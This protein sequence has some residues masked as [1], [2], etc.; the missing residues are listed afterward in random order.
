MK[1]DGV[2]KSAPASVNGNAKNADGYQ[3]ITIDLGDLSVPEGASVQFTIP[4]AFLQTTSGAQYN[5]AFSG[6]YTMM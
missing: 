6:A 2:S 4:S 3:Y 5:S 1:V